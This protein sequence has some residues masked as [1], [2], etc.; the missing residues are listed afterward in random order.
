MTSI[1]IPMDSELKEKAEIL[2]NEIGLNVAMTIHKFVEKWVKD[3]KIPI[4]TIDDGKVISFSL[5]EL[6]AM[7]NEAKNNPNYKYPSF[8]EVFE[9]QSKVK[10]I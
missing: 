9:Q 7:S 2:S 6:E 3:G 1:T 8:D 4:E 10:Y 5:D